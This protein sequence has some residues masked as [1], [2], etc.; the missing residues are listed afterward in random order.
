MP[1]ITL[2]LKIEKKGQTGE[3]SYLCQ[4][5]DLDNFTAEPYIKNLK[6]ILD[7]AQKDYKLK[8]KKK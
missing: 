4:V 5:D 2:T 7:E 8:E 6:R 3:A 1:T